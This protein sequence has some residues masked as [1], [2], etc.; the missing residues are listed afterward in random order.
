MS[1][2]LAFRDGVKARKRHRCVLCGEAIVAGDL[3]DIRT[4]VNSDGFW[5]MHMHPECHEIEHGN[6]DSD[7]YEDCSEP[8]FERPAAEKAKGGA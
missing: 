3:Y 7:W 2:T 6:V 1:E 8:A 5:T 4:G